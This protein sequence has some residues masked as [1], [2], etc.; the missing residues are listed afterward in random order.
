MIRATKIGLVSVAILGLSFFRAS[1]QTVPDFKAMTLEAVQK[2]IPLIQK[3]ATGFSANTKC[4]SCH[5]QSLPQMTMAVARIRGFVIDEKQAKAQDVKVYEALLQAKP[6]FQAAPKSKAAES[7]LD[8]NLVDPAMTVGYLMAGMASSQQKS[9]GLTGLIAQYVAQKQDVSGRWSV[10]TA[11]P[12]MEASEFAAT[13][14]NVRA[15]K[16]Y[17]PS[18]PETEARITKAR[19]WLLANKPR[20]TEDKAFRLF[21]LGWTNADKTAISKA[22][23][24]LLSD[25]RDDG[26][27][28]Q[29]PNMTSDAYATGEALVALYEAGK[30]SVTASAYNRGRFFLLTTQAMDG[31]WSVPKRAI[32]VQG[33]VE[34]GYPYENAQYISIGGACWATIALMYSVEGPDLKPSAAKL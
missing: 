22:I 1:A 19:T 8:N 24:D 2:S 3:G 5:N 11:R 23:E 15:L 32:S 18:S 12:P 17:A 31:S 9:D 26:G 6:L 16:T 33:Y 10:H 28:S 30:M 34:T 25:Q 14:L 4:V 21:G 20:N 27:W 7:A 29:L 13:S